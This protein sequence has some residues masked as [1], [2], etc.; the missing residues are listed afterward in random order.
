MRSHER[1]V[2]AASA[3]MARVRHECTGCG[4]S[5]EECEMAR[6]KPGVIACC[7]DCHHVGLASRFVVDEPVVANVGE[8]IHSA[9]RQRHL[10]QAQMAELVGVNR[11]TISRYESGS[12]SPSARFLVDL[13]QALQAFDHESE[14][15]F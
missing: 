3:L 13:F 9:R 1:Q 7:P 8:F 5:L 11:V 2:S 15:V 4:L 14:E 10:T 6:L 12:R